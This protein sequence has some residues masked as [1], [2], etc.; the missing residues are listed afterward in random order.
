MSRFGL[1][2]AWQTLSPVEHQSVGSSFACRYLSDDPSK[3][4]SK[5]EADMLR[6]GGIDVVVVWETTAQRALAGEAAGAADARS[7][8]LKADACGMPKDRPIY[9]AVDFDCTSPPSIDPYF[10]G[11]AGVLGKDRCGPYGDFNVVDHL[12]G[13]GFAYGWQTYAW[14]GTRVSKHATLYQFSNDHVVAGHQVDFNRALKAD[15]GQ[16]GYVKPVAKPTGTLRFNGTLDFD[17]G[18]WHIA[19]SGGSSARAGGHDRTWDAHLRVRETSL[20]LE[21]EPLPFD[22]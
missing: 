20:G 22:K 15:F 11:V 18:R 4:I 14:S 13:K 16:W 7:A 2:Y 12:G 17:N 9:F 5:A 21:I 6:A 8:M 10:A 19:R 1:D 3:D